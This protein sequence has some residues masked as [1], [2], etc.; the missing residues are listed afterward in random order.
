MQ[1]RLEVLEVTEEVTVSADAVPVSPEQNIDRFQC[2]DTFLGGL[3][4]LD[5]DPLAVVSM[6]TDPSVAGARGPQ[7]IVDGVPT[8]TLDLPLSSIKNITVNQNPYSAEFGRPG[9]GRIEVKTKRRIHKFHGTVFTDF[10]NSAFDARN[11]FAS[12]VPPHQRAV[13]EAELEGPISKAVSFL[14]SARYDL[15]NETS[16]VDAQTLSGPLVQNFGAPERNT[17]LF[18]RLHF[19]LSTNHKLSFTYKFKDKLLK[20]RN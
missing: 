2:D 1:I 14:V 4:T 16:I 15:N 5:G 17:H 18:G 19:K 10:Q 13:S 11:T 7:L 3:P 9:K 20:N 8:D 12:S 6:F